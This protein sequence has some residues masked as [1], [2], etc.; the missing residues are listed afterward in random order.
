MPV[1]LYL[2]EKMKT[3]LESLAMTSGIPLGQFV[4]EILASHFLGHTVWPERTQAWTPE[5]K[6]LADGWIDGRIEEESFRWY[7]VE[8]RDALDGRIE[9]I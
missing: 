3:D 1:K 8:E 6:E 5:Q 2:H 4:R 9:T 7:T